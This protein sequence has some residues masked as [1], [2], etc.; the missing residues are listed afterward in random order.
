MELDQ[1]ILNNLTQLN[2]IKKNT[3]FT[4]KI[5]NIYF[6]NIHIVEQHFSS[7]MK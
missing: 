7:F 6:N 1:A 5:H 2:Y 4:N 3:F